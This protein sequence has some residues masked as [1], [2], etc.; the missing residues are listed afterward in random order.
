M[1]KTAD[2]KIN[3]KLFCYILVLKKINELKSTSMFQA[4]Y[5][6]AFPVAVKHLHI[7]KWFVGSYAYV[8]QKLQ[9]CKIF[10]SIYMR[11]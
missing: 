7:F 10:I 9:G 6:L 2:I 5:F 1:M 8:M 3:T 4:L 11:G